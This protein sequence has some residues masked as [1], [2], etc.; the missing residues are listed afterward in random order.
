LQSMHAPQQVPSYYSDMYKGYYED[1]AIM[2]GMAT[3]SD[4][5][6]GNMTAALKAKGMWQNTLIVVTSDNGGPSGLPVVSS[7]NNFPLRGGKKGNFEGGIRVAST[8]GGGFLPAKM[9]GTTLDG[10]MHASDWYPTFCGL[11]GVDAA[12]PNPKATEVPGVDGFDL[13][14]YISGTVESS[15][16]TEIMISAEDN[17][18]II[19]GDYKM[20]VG[21][22]NYGFWTALNYPNKSFDHSTVKEVDCGKGCLFD[23]RGDPS[24]YVD[25]ATSMPDKLD[26]LQKLHKK[27]SATSYMPPNMEND[28][29]RCS[30]Y[31]KEH[32][33]FLGPY[34]SWQKGVLT[35]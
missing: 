17:G 14:P 24:E 1:F 2:N 3:V 20:I 12:D 10:Y 32:Q 23:I 13:W 5:V 4:E 34:Y 27:R 9:V 6:L 15:P 26:E 22:Q 29:A 28:A 21:V 8:I 18:G 30:A 33:G 11:A 25:L 31:L 7:G 35:V 16:R 19:S